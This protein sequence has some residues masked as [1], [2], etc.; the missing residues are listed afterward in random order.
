MPCQAMA[1]DPKRDEI[2]YAFRSS[3]VKESI[4]RFKRIDGSQ[5]VDSDT[6]VY[7]GVF[8]E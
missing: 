7:S 5:G 3:T 2:Y 1:Y 6:A 4:N 8:Y